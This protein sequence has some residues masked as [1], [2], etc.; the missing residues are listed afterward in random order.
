MGRGLRGVPAG[1][2]ARR[3]GGVPAGEHEQV[4]GVPRGAEDVPRQG[5]GLHTDEVHRGRRAGEVQPP[6]RR[7]RG[8]PPARHVADAWP[9]N[10]RSTPLLAT[11]ARAIAGRLDHARV[12]IRRSPQVLAHAYGLPCPRS[13]PSP[14][15]CLHETLQ[16]AAGAR[17][18]LHMLAQPRGCLREPPKLAA[19]AGPCQRSSPSPSRVGVACPE[20]QDIRG[21]R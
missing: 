17:A 5:D 7:R 9:S 14:C 6:A 19:G 18:R 3:G 16:H 13:S 15:R 1:A 20:S 12:R 4:P 11:P 2:V 10:H 8:A 21:Q